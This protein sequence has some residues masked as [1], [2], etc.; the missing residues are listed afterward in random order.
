MSCFSPHIPTVVS[1]WNTQW[2][3]GA[4]TLGPYQREQSLSESLYIL[5]GP[6]GVGKVSSAISSGKVPPRCTGYPCGTKFR[7]SAASLVD[8]LVLANRKIIRPNDVPSFVQFHYLTAV[9]SELGVFLP[10]MIH[11]L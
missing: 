1:N 3:Y 5:V 11:S 10:S 8:S 2:S 7:L 9:A 4:A 6:P